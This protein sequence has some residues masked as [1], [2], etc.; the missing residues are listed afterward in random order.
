MVD[1]AQSAYYVLKNA[2]DTLRDYLG[3]EVTSINSE[4]TV[5]GHSCPDPQD[6]DIF[7]GRLR[8][9]PQN[10]QW[11]TLFSSSEFERLGMNVGV[12]RTTYRIH[13]VSGIRSQTYRTDEGAGI[14][15]ARTTEDAGHL[16]AHLLSRAV[17]TV[18]QRRLLVVPKIV[19]VLFLGR[20]Q[21]S[22]RR[23]SPDV[24]EIESRYDVMV[25]THNSAFT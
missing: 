11:I 16:R 8:V 13:V 20:S 3:T 25:E 12:S 7:V 9:P 6:A 15:K 19:N 17:H 22:Q 24:F 4:S 5:V 1:T 2:R 23:S 18:I 14:V 10:E 21:Q